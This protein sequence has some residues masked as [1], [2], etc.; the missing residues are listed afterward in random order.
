M[1]DR[2]ITVT[3]PSV[4]TNDTLS[5]YNNYSDID[6]QL[7]TTMTPTEAT[8]GHTVALSDGVVH[9]VTT[10]PVGTTNGEFS[11]VVSN[12][13]TVD[14]TI[15]TP[16]YGLQ[17]SSTSALVNN[18]KPWIDGTTL[19]MNINAVGTEGSVVYI[20]G[21]DISDGIQD[22]VTLRHR[23]VGQYALNVSLVEGTD[24]AVSDGDKVKI[25]RVGQVFSFYINDVLQQEITDAI[26]PATPTKSQLTIGS[27]KDNGAGGA[28][29]TIISE[30]WVDGEHFPMEENT[31]TTVTGDD[32]TVF[33]FVGTPTWVTL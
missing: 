11:A 31:G 9:E 21:N 33:D 30:F 19:E 25:T 10:K 8:N 14:L 17:F 20:S 18:N 15:A 5:G 32:G 13:V 23:L 27:F 6:G 16:V 22:V 24:Y 3:N 2:I 1:A 12:A 7:G 4:V 26:Y 29:D 28:T